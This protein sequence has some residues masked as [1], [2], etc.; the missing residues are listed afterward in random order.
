MHIA[1]ALIKQ[2]TVFIV[3]G[4]S[5]DTPTKADLLNDFGTSDE[6]LCIRKI[7]VAGTS[8]HARAAA[9]AQLQRSRRRSV[10]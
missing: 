5:R 4:G 2:P 3:R 9:D 7:L 10:P 1:F 8:N 6:Q